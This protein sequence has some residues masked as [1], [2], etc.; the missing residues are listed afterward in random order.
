M[1]AAGPAFEL[2]TPMPYVAVQQMLDGAFP[3]GIHAY[4]KS[5]YLEDFTD[6]AAAVFAEHVQRRRSPMTQAILFDMGG[7]FADV[8]DADT[9]FGGSRSARW[10]VVLDAV[11]PDAELLAADREWARATFDAMRPFAENAGGYVNLMAEYDED[12][13]RATYGTEKYERLA[14]IKGVYDPGN[15]FHLN[16]NIKPS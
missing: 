12:R 11:A 14:R 13:V 5:L 16:A 3:W 4:S 6:A 2:V 9:A 1:R 15:V 7:A 8:A 10:T